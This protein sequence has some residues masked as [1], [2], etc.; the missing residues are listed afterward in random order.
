MSGKLFIVGILI[1]N[2][3][4]MLKC[5]IDILNLVDFIVC[6]DIWV[7]IKFLNYFGIKKK[8][9]F[10]YEFSLKEKEEKIIYELK[11]GKK[12]VFVFDVGMFFI[13]DFGYEFVWRCIEEGIEVIV[14]FGFFVFVCVLVFFG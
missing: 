12:I 13:L 6:E 14:V 11:S 4:D 10:F 2:L 1:G 3:D 5:V 9:V 8:F 7:I